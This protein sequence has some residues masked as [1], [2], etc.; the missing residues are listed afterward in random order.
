MYIYLYMRGH[1]DAT[2]TGLESNR[3]GPEIPAQVS[4]KILLW[5]T[6]IVTSGGF[7]VWSDDVG[8]TLA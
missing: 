8:T 6:V 1:R 2:G 4:I 7:N 3:R 5:S